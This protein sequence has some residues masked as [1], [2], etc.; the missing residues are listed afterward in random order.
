MFGIALKT[1]GLRR[2]IIILIEV[3][4]F[5]SQLHCL[6]R[7]TIEIK[8]EYSNC[9]SRNPWRRSKRTTTILFLTNNYCWIYSNNL[10]WWYTVIIHR[11]KLSNWYFKFI[12]FKITFEICIPYFLA[13]FVFCEISF[14]IRMFNSS[15]EMSEKWEKDSL[16]H[17]LFT[18][19]RHYHLIHSDY[20]GQ[21]DCSICDR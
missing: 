20:D 9:F 11:V 18:S 3:K 1:T 19:C 6:L 10:C 17:Y 16:L 4:N 13:I 7:L 12:F 2:F 21:S 8:S 15:S 14:W 5:G